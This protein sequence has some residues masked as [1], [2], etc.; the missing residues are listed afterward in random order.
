MRKAIFIVAT[1][2][3]MTITAAAVQA[4]PVNYF[5]NGGCPYASG[6]VPGDGVINDNGVGWKVPPT[7]YVRTRYY[8]FGNF[9]F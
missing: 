3:A 2:V 4:Q 1:L 7:F 9:C 8:F 5:W 6:W